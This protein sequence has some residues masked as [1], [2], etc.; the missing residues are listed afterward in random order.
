[1][2]DWNR[3]KARRA[4]PRWRLLASGAGA[5]LVILLLL[6]YAVEV[7]YRAPERSVTVGDPSAEELA[8]LQLLGRALKFHADDH[9]GKFPARI[10][11]IE[12][13]Q[14]VPGMDWPGLP[15]A[16]SRFH[17]PETGRVSDWL[18][19]EGHTENDPPDTILAASPVALGKGNDHRMIVRVDG[20]AQ[21]IAE[22]DF[23]R[24]MPA[25]DA[26]GNGR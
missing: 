4:R 8:H 20:V 26:P 3:V 25:Q 22:T 18:Y 1:M 19:Y 21:V 5:A 24:L 17:N 23:Q 12:W 7:H 14:D 15:A 16:V 9:D 11:D 10:A 6:F 13:R 2:E